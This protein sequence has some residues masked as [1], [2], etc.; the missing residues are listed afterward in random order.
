MMEREQES[1]PSP[2]VQMGT[3]RNTKDK[4]LL[5]VMRSWGWNSAMP[6]TRACLKPGT[7]GS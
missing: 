6:V 5:E 3:L 7:V 2:V 4:R 1:H